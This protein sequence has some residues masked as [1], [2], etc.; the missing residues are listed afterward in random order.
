M[1][2]LTEIRIRIC[3]VCCAILIP[4]LADLY[5]PG[6]EWQGILNLLTTCLISISLGCYIT[7]FLIVFKKWWKE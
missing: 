1:K 6:S 3:G 2:P 4:L 5:P 7:N